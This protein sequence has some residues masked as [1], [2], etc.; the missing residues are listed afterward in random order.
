MPRRLRS[1]TPFASVASICLLLAGSALPA[2]SQEAIIYSFAGGAS[3]GASPSSA[4]VVDKAGNLYGTTPQGGASGCGTVFELSPQANGVWAETLIYSFVKEGTLCAGIPGPSLVLDSQGN[5]YSTGLGGAHG[6]GF[7]YELSPSVSGWTLTDLYDFHPTYTYRDGFYPYAGVTRD[8]EGNLYGTTYLGGIGQCG[9]SEGVAESKATG[10]KPPKG[11]TSSGCG[12]VFEL[13]RSSSGGW[14]E[15]ILYNFRAGTDG[16]GPWANLTLD[17]TGN[18]FGTTSGGGTGY[19]GCIGVY[20]SGC[21][22]VFELSP[23]HGASWKEHVLYSFTGDT[24]GG[25]PLAGVVLDNAGNLYGTTPGPF[26]EYGSVYEL[27]PTSTGTWTETTLSSFV[28]ETYG[29]GAASSLIID[30]AG[31]VYGTTQYGAGPTGAALLSSTG[32]TAPPPKPFGPGTIFEITPGQ[33]GT[34]TT[35]WLYTFAGTPDGLAPSAGMVR[36]P[37]GALYGTTTS[38]G[39]FGY[40][41]IYKFVP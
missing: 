25:V 34:W 40:G 12:I 18:L 1:L 15:K 14:A 37:D 23:A 28:D 27:S 7:V 21:G 19:G 3:D 26:S 9:N 20:I 35:S 5:L 30:E 4:L 33:S 6:A 8:H 16:A 11:N 39:S 38:G 13:S 41:A 31:K 17:A 22:T 32:R 24:D 2:T 29:F 36:G 10:S